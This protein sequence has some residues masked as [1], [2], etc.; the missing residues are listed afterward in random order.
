MV[1]DVLIWSDGELT[2]RLETSL[3]RDAAVELAATIP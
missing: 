3:G 2:Y 1:G